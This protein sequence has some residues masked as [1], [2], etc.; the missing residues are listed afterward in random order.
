M[1]PRPVSRNHSSSARLGRVRRQTAGSRASW[2]C[3]SIQAICERWIWPPLSSIRFVDAKLQTAA[4]GLPGGGEPVALQRK[5]QHLHRFVRCQGARRSTASYMI[6]SPVWKSSYRLIFD[7]KRESTLEG[8]AIIDNTTGEDWNN[9]RLSRLFPDARFRLSASCMSR[10]IS[11]P[12][13]GSRR[14]IGRR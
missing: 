5:A 8:W 3:C 12:D 14:R 6:P 13:G 4:Q 11:A 1:A 10:N 9:V 7:D 2:C